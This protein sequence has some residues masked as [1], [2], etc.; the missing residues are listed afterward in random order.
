MLCTAVST[1]PTRLCSSPQALVMPRHQMASLPK[2]M[3]SS[4]TS[5]RATYLAG[6]WPQ[7]GTQ[8]LPTLPV[9]AG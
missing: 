1:P 8:L 4:V 6:Q 2:P 9:S 5:L 3:C 7:H